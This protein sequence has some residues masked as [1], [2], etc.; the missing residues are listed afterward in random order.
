M[1]SE[2]LF[3]VYNE[4]TEQKEE[5]GE[6]VESISFPKGRLF[7]IS[8][9]GSILVDEKPRTTFIG[10]FAE[11]LKRLYNEEYRFVLVAGGG[12][13]S[14]HYIAA[15]KALG[16][17]NFAQDMLGISA[18]RL[19]ALLLA[20]AIENAYPTVLTRVES[21]R[22]ILACDMI[23]VYGGLLPGITTDCVAALIAEYLE[24]ELI[25]MTNVKGIYSADPKEKQ[26]ATLYKKL[27]PDALIKLVS[28][29]TS[30]PGQHVVLDLPACLIIKRSNI[31]TIVLHGEDLENFER[32]VRG[33]EF[34]GTV[35]EEETDKE[36]ELE[37]I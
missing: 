2:E 9:G 13:T 36:G 14:R 1:F 10:K 11:V 16:A 18:S 27:T 21:S 33:N 15:S 8:V 17:S 34:E 35:I 7:V 30:K 37:E 26:D 5:T 23:P 32:A 20:N 25:N 12:T 22:H 29:S 6:E 31:R 3:K 28:A 19:N 24:A 4:Q